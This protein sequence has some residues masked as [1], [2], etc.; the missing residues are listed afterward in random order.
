[1][2]TVAGSDWVTKW[3]EEEFATD[4]DSSF[5]LLLLIP[6]IAGS[7]VLISALGLLWLYWRKKTQEKTHSTAQTECVFEEI[8]T[9]TVG[10]TSHPS[11]RGSSA[12]D[13]YQQQGSNHTLRILLGSEHLR[14]RRIPFDTIEFERA[15]AKGASGKIWICRYK[16]NKVAV[17][18]L[19]QTKEQKAENVQAFAEEIELNASLIHPNIVEFIGVAWNSLSNLAMMIEYVPEGN[20]RDFLHQNCRGLEIK[21]PS[22]LESPKLWII[23]TA[24]HRN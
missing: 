7:V 23:Y 5:D 18:R 10:A 13:T 12:S 2:A 11:T 1:M 3:L 16:D 15:L 6:I 20:L 8:S 14:E 24:D 17:K 22:P 9:P 21:S 4:S 19:L